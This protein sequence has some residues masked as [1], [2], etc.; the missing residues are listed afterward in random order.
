MFR[1]SI[2]E[3][4]Y[5]QVMEERHAEAVYSVVDN[6]REHL[7]RWLPW[8]DRTTEPEYTRKFIQGALEQFARNEGFSAA[9]WVGGRVAGGIGFHKLDWQ[10]KNV[11]MGYWI[12]SEFERRG[13]VTDASRALIHHAFTEWKLNRVEIR[14][15]TRNLRS[16]AIPK[17][18][19]F[20]LEGTLREAQLLSD[21]YH[22]LHVFGMLA[23]EWGRNSTPHAS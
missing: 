17:R 12:S 18:L 8:V 1:V 19:G 16:A 15:A 7:R 20:T 13:I 10:Y 11:E 23:K 4:A 21:G 2:R 3:N 22:D 6:D 9:I 14:C 5:L